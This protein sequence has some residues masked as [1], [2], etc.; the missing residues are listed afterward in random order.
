MSNGV[1][2][3]RNRKV[4]P[5]QLVLNDPLLEPL[6]L[7]KDLKVVV[8]CENSQSAEA[9]CGLLARLA[10][11]S[12]ADGRLIYGWWN[13]DVLTIAALRPLAAAETALADMVVVAARAGPGL[14]AEVIE[15]MS[16]WLAAGEH[17]CRALVAL[18]DSGAARDRA[19]GGIL[20][21]LK[22]VAELGQMDFFA[23]GTEAKLVAAL[24]RGAAPPS[25]NLAWRQELYATNCRTDR[26]LKV[27]QP[28][29]KI[30]TAIEQN[31][32]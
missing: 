28:R 23:K 21:Q 26:N 14:P 10:L 25:G 7:G 24:K 31:K 1:R 8:A 2:F 32:K 22:K 15:W 12:A 18:L 3:P 17:R 4:C 19:A 30:K 9:A 27:G 20:A 13:F 11:N 29:Y 6:E 16:L 5:M